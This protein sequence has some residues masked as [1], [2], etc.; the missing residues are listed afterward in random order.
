TATQYALLSSL[1]ALPRT[2]LSA[3][4]GFVAEA[5]AWTDFFI[6]TAVG[7]VPGLLILWW[8]TRPG[9]AVRPNS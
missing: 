4:S 6:F 8:L 9:S 5:L 1:F 3:G 7:A 2:L